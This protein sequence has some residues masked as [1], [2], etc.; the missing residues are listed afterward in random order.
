MEE[1]Q[2]NE[3]L[4]PD[5]HEL[6]LHGD[7]DAQLHRSSHEPIIKNLQKKHDKGTY[8]H[9]KSKT[10]WKYHSDRAAQSYHKQ[11]GHPSS[12]WHEMFPVHVRHEAASHWADHNAEEHGWSKEDH[13]HVN[14]LADSTTARYIRAASDSRAEAQHDLG[15]MKGQIGKNRDQKALA[16]VRRTHD[17]IE[18][19]KTS[20]KRGIGINRATRKLG[21]LVDE[22][23]QLDE[24]KKS[25]LASY[26]KKA[27]AD[28]Q[29]SSFR[30]G[31]FYGKELAT[32]R[33]TKG[34]AAE[35][36]KEARISANRATGINRAT[37]RL[38]K[39]DVEQI[40]EISTDL[41]KR[42]RKKAGP[43][44][45]GLNDRYKEL[46][47]GHPDSYKHLKG[48]L[49]NMKRHKEKRAQGLMSATRRINKRDDLHEH[50][51]KELATREKNGTRGMVPTN[52][53]ENVTEELAALNEGKYKK[54]SEV[55]QIDELKKSTLAS[56]NKKAASSL[57]TNAKMA[58]LYKNTSGKRGPM[59]FPRDLLKAKSANNKAF[60][61]ER[62]I[63]RATD[64]LT[65]TFQHRGDK[66][67]KYKGK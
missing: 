49:K 59:A 46:T 47:T 42:Y 64:R 35:S 45:A 54:G 32:Q 37:D 26:V 21:G 30:H 11:H 24:L 40:D 9:A 22:A 60:N 67:K 20:D 27:A 33:R 12:K 31:K 44:W 43:D 8:I 23:D 62:G 63:M 17:Y 65:G 38:A 19:R 3:G 39:E 28:G 6:V 58:V 51:T 18:A 53:R 5:A 61:R 36:K 15:K 25:T 10:L 52:Q 14:E 56:Y 50:N 7:N 29:V 66:S 13:H 4:S 48:S 57:Y 34:D 16:D 2:I 1:T 55:E 41:A